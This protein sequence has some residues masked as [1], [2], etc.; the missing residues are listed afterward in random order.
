ML[1]VGSDSDYLRFPLS[2][3]AGVL[4]GNRYNMSLPTRAIVKALYAQATSRIFASPLTASPDMQG[5]GY[6]YFYNQYVVTQMQAQGLADG[7][8]IEGHKKNP[9]LSG[10]CATTP[11]KLDF[12][13]WYRPNGQPWQTN[14]AHGAEYADYSHGIRLVDNMVE[15]LENGQYR[16][17]TLVTLLAQD[18]YAT[19]LNDGDRYALPTNGTFDASRCYA[20]CTKGP[21]FCSFAQNTPWL[22]ALLDAFP[23]SNFE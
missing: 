17:D 15:V 10:Y 4:I 14:P 22:K 20:W 6:L 3:Y 8:W 1:S 12:F 21:P 23:P 7:S 5:G 18:R 11:A 2:P 9:I 16:T 19:V 13:G